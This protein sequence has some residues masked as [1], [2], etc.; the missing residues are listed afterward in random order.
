MTWQTL[1]RLILLLAVLDASRV[2]D[3]AVTMH[4]HDLSKKVVEVRDL[5]SL[6]ER[7]TEQARRKFISFVENK[8]MLCNK[9]GD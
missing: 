6:R 5:R 9:Y 8:V 3:A 7:T 2:T 4:L 1:L